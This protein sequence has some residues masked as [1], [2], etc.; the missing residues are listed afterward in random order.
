MNLLKA[1]YNAES[2]KQIIIGLN[3]SIKTIE[4]IYS[5]D[6]FYLLE[7]SEPVFGMAFIAFQNYIN[8]SIKDLFNTTENKTS[9]YILGSRSEKYERS[10]IELIIALAN[11]IKH[12]DESKLHKGTQSILDAFNLE[13]SSIIEES[14]IF[15]GLSILDE[16]WDI[17]KVYEMVTEWRKDL[18]KGYD[19]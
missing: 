10:N 1:D 4:E 17:F 8:S 5:F 16:K 7:K 3:N 15:G 14:P 19:S 12:K 11:Y 6:G 9:Y 2:L 13:P 18:F